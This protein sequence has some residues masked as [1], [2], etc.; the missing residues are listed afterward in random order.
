M[1][2]LRTLPTWVPSWEA[3]AACRHGIF[4][5][6]SE[7]FLE[8]GDVLGGPPLCGITGCWQGCWACKRR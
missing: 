1:C 5:Q 3:R 7:S 8:P 2:A 6:R 4:R